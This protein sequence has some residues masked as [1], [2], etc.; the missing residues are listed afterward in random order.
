M[1]WSLPTAL[2]RTGAPAL[3][4]FIALTALLI[5]KR[6][7]GSSVA[8]IV[9]STALMMVAVWLVLALVMYLAKKVFA[10]RT[11]QR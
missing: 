6:E 2:K 11:T 9:Q 5:A 3:G 1:A 10:P 7:P 8:D 4:V